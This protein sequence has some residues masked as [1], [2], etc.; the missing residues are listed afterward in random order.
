MQMAIRAKVQFLRNKMRHCD[1]AESKNL[2][3]PI[4]VTAVHS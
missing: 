3:A 1:S 2:S 4:M